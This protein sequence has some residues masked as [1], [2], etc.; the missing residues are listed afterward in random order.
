MAKSDSSHKLKQRHH[1]MAQPRLV[2]PN[3]QSDVTFFLQNCKDGDMELPRSIV[4]GFIENLNNDEFNEISQIVQED[5]KTSFSKDK[6]LPKPLS[7]EEKEAFIEK[8]NIKVPESQKQEY[9][10]LIA[11]HDD[12]F[13]T[14]KNDLARAMNFTH[15]I[16][17]KDNILEAISYSRSPQRC[18]GRSSW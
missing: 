13:S 5:V 15:K 8:A 9:I 14:S 17:L 16:E 4:I 7:K 10:D 3:H 12:V 2:V 1:L 11:G 18:G 6:P